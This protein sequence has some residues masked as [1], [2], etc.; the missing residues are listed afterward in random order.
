MKPFIISI[1]LLLVQTLNLFAQPQVKEGNPFIRNFTPKDYKGAEQNWAIVQDR[2]N[3]MYFGNGNGVMEY[4]GEDFRFIVLPNQSL[5]RSLA[6]D[7]NDRIYVGGI[8]EIGYLEADSIGRLVYKSYLNR[9]DSTHRNFSDVWVTFSTPDG[10]YYFTHNIIFLANNQN[11]KIWKPQTTPFSNAFMANNRL[12]VHSI[13]QGLMFLNDDQNMEL[14]PGGDRFKND[15]VY[16]VIQ[17]NPERILITTRNQGLIF[18]DSING[19]SKFRTEADEFLKK[20]LVYCSTPLNSNMIAYGTLRGGV[21]IINKEGKLIKKLDKGSGITDD[22]IYSAYCDNQSNLWLGLGNGISMIEINHPI[23]TYNELKGLKGTITSILKY[24]RTLYVATLTGTY[25]L[26]DNQFIQCFGMTE[27][28]WKLVNF[29]YPDKDKSTLLAGTNSGIYEIT[30]NKARLIEKLWNCINIYVSKK[31]KGRI[32]VAT[33]TK[34]VILD[35][36]NGKW[37]NKGIVFDVNKYVRSIVEDKD[38]SLWVGGEFD[39]V[40]HIVFGNPNNLHSTKTIKYDLDESDPNHNNIKII[41][42]YKK[43]LF[44]DNQSI[45][46]YNAN[47]NNFIK[48]TS[49]SIYLPGNIFHEDNNHNLW[50]S[51]NTANYQ[52]I[53]YLKDFDSNPKWYDMPFRRLPEMTIYA[54]YSDTNNITWFGGTELLFR[55]DSQKDI[56][57]YNLK[58][59]ALI[60]KVTIK[61]DS[62]IYYG[63]SN[64]NKQKRTPKIE[65]KENYIAFN[66]STPDFSNKDNL[67]YQYFLE[68]FDKEWSSFTD[69]KYK[70]YNHLQHGQYIFRVRAINT[71][72]NISNE[73]NYKFIILTPWHRTL[74]AYFTYV[75]TL[76]LL[77]IITVRLFT[78]RLKNLNKKLEKIVKERTFK[79]NQQNIELEQHRNHLEK[80]V[81]ERTADLKIAKEKAEESDKLKSA[82]LTN[83]SHEIRTPMNAIIGFSGLLDDQEIDENEKKTFIK[84]VENNSKILLRLI[85]DILDIAKIE[86]KQLTIRKNECDI[87]EILNELYQLFLEK[88]KEL[89]K[90]NIDISIIKPNRKNNLIVYTDETRFR[91]ILTNIIDNALKFTD[92]GYIKFGYILNNQKIKFFV[93]DSGIGLSLSEQ[94]QIFN[95]FYKIQG[96]RRKIYG[97]AG[98]GLTICKSLAQMLGGDIWLESEYKKGSTFYFTISNSG[99]TQNIDSNHITVKTDQKHNW[100]GYNIII[101]EDEDS[102]YNLICKFLEKTRIS[103]KRANNGKEVIE[104]C[105]QQK[106][107]LI[108]MD[109]KL[110][111]MDGL[112]ATSKIKKSFPEIPIIAVTAFA[113]N[114]DKNKAFESGCDDYL[115]K[116]FLRSDLL[117]IL[118]SFF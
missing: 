95:R 105:N 45:Y 50:I 35:Y 111:V 110:P 31:N 92:E 2:R 88:R 57:N 1:S 10:T 80:L 65:C 54:I 114:D 56:K 113:M 82:F 53:G 99:T 78:R 67:N 84:H 44:A 7:K 94:K 79:V 28:T 23:S 42:C 97:G 86:S 59:H 18:Y 51:N 26:E 47:T 60:R 41:E 58:Y 63:T 69:K 27:N 70:E 12:F 117:S 118:N 17:Y 98:L 9:I 19:Y 46:S 13:G 108:L 33:E 81:M 116:P 106:P 107:D 25:Y 75:T 72:G 96:D 112:E 32:Y 61:Q 102:N 100:S 76:I 14:L 89:N 91:Q 87:D 38:G 90:E 109:I 15:R 48:D 101:A 104:Y 21:V 74:Y 6:I 37:Q 3:V 4:D 16:S 20:N 22:V 5:V 77:I 64:Q 29:K 39:G 40:Y 73:A 83:M 66:Y 36:V 30:N 52:S 115:S 62:I 103:I 24:N 68:G 8:G 11:V 93:E 71:Y 55:Y 49:R 43:V 34:I 85:D